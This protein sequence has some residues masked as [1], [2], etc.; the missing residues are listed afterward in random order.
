MAD[1][2]MSN[3]Q[4]VKKDYRDKKNDFS[5]SGAGHGFACPFELCCHAAWQLIKILV[6]L[7]FPDILTFSC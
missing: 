6:G 7:A 3:L 4:K 2:T 5:Q 1:Q